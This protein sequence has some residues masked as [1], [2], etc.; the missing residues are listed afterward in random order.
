MAPVEPASRGRAVARLLMIQNIG[1]NV[2]FAV[3]FLIVASA[4][5]PSL[6]T[7]FLVLI[8]FVAARN[9]G[10]AF[11]QLVDR[12][13]DARN[14]RTQDRPIVTGA[15]SPGW[16]GAVVAANVA[17]LLVAA[18]LLRLEV[19]LLAPLALLVIFGYSYT[20]RFTATTTI[21]LGAVQALIPTGV[22]LAITG[23]LPLAAWAAIIGCLLFGTS[24]ESIHSLGDLESDR[25]LGLKSLPL[26]LG[27]DRTPLLVAG[28]LG[29][30][31]IAFADFGHQAALSWPFFVALV[32]FVILAGLVVQG[33][34][35]T[36]PS[37]PLLFRAHFL[38][39]AFFLV[40]CL[41]GLP[42]SLGLG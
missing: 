29:G 31:V 7:A 5:H 16:A 11:N 42:L 6:F 35:R 10:H 39:G 33:L 38:M 40:G 23:G 17:V 18:D 27:R 36:Q 22:Y 24:F 14:P 9:A 26:L 28:A 2:F 41:A 37:L 13:Y 1:L 25:E 20:K 8:A 32:G 12:S 21:L 15:V 4:G 3:A 34:R 19:L 30:A